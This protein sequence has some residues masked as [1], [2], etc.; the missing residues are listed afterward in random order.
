M[1]TEQ[2]EVVE[3]L[4]QQLANLQ[5]LLNDARK[6]MAESNALT[7]NYRKRLFATIDELM[8]AQANATQLKA[9]L[10]QANLALEQTTNNFSTYLKDSQN[11]LMEQSKQLTIKQKQLDQRSARQ[12][13]LD[14]VNSMSTKLLFDLMDTPAG[15]KRVN[16]YL[17]H[18]PKGTLI[19]VINFTMCEVID[20]PIEQE[21]IL[22]TLESAKNFDDAN[23]EDYDE[24][25]A[26]L[27]RH[28]GMLA[29]G[30]PSY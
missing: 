30:H 5:M 14:V 13:T 4:D 2:N 12:Q 29:K 23:R 15:R 25:Y 17:S 21:K 28:L 27:I 16:T 10:D 19:D 9:D 20:E 1:S 18:S 3:D 8:Q 6:A 24:R 22:P 11:R 7:S 26:T